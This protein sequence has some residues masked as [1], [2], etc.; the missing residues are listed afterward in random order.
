MLNAVLE[1]GDESAA[2]SV[3]PDLTDQPRTRTSVRIGEG[4]TVIEI[5]A[6]DTSAMR[7]AL[8]SCL[9]CISIT[10]DIGKITR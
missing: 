3:G 4:K 2:A 1:I 9:E 5:T 8:N 6:A 7:A 10:E